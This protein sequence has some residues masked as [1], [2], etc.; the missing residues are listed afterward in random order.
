[1][2]RTPWWRDA[3]VYEIYVRSF[4]DSDGDGVGD[5]PGIRSRLPYL[6]GLGVDAIW[7][8]PFYPSPQVDHGYDVADYRDVEPLF[9]T[10]VDFDRLLRD[11][12][13]LGLRVI[14]DIVPNHTSSAHTWFQAA[15][16]SPPGS[17]ERARYIFRTGRGRGGNRP[18]NNWPSHFGGPAWTQVRDG[19]WYLHLF[20]AGQPDLDWTN[21]EVGDEFDSILRFWL[22]RGVDGFRVDVA[23]GLAKA[24]GLPDTRRGT[25]LPFVDQP[26]VHDVYRRWRTVLDSYDGERMAVA[27]AWSDDA[28]L[29][30]L[31]T[32]PDE[33]HQAFNFHF[34]VADWSAAAF[35]RV[36][37]DGLRSTATIGAAATWVLSSHDQLRH[38]SRYG[39]GELGLSRALAATM[40]MLA[41]PGSGYLYQGEE[42]GLPQVDVAPT[43]RQDPS[44]E[45]SGHT[46][47]GRDGCRVP[48]PWSGA[49][50]PYGFGPGAASAWLP[51]PEDWAPLTV[52]A[53]AG[54][55]GSTL[56]LYRT[57]LALR[58]AH[59]AGNDA[60][61]DWL[62]SPVGTLAFSRGGLVCTTN[63]APRP[64][65]V[66]VDGRALISSNGSV[67]DADG[68]AVLPPATTVWWST[69]E[70]S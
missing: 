41:L 51:Q 37:D 1:V 43:D 57:A 13:E 9:G 68:T 11:A 29:R 7:L 36:V 52:E 38:V 26:P 34:Q 22:D 2:P 48:L 69:R 67:P 8:T 5:L 55:D 46:I 6:A 31:Y 30:A 24:A 49:S 65:R 39:G 58:R 3:V 40:F 35:R 56:E 62:A 66:R 44:W 70:P 45:R 64:R 33:L 14:I 10:L 32:R 12:H 60:P 54:Q 4:A 42:L 23:N 18:P 17:P 25:P 16:S 15:L 61:L 19:E 63:F 59:V 28:E 47:V 53:Q 50:P 21:A 20:D 27:E